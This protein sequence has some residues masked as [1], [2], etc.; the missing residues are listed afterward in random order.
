M[1]GDFNAHVGSTTSSA[2]EEGQWDNNGGPHG[3]GE[4]NGSAQLRPG[5]ACARY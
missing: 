1:L 5:S 3:F 4:V 2:M